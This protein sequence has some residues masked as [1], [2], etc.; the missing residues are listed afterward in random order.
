MSYLHVY[1]VWLTYADFEGVPADSLRVSLH[2]LDGAIVIV[3]AGVLI[4]VGLLGPLS[5]A[6]E[7][8]RAAILVAMGY[9]LFDLALFCMVV[10]SLYASAGSLTAAGRSSS[11]PCARRTGCR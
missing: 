10:L 4:A 9:P 2:S 5:T 3:V 8:T 1:R 11:A 6:S 7:G